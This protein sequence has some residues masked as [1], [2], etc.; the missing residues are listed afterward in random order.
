M[1]F[2]GGLLKSRNPL[3]VYA[4]I[5]VQWP[6]RRW[7]AAT[8]MFVHIS[9]RIPP[10]AKYY[11]ERGT[12]WPQKL[13]SGVECGGAQHPKLPPRSNTTPTAHV[14]IVTP[15]CIRRIARLLDAL[16]GPHAA[17]DAVVD[18]AL[19]C[20][21][22]GEG[23]AKGITPVAGDAGGSWGCSYLWGLNTHKSPRPT[24]ENTNTKTRK[25]ENRHRMARLL[26]PHAQAGERGSKLPC[27]HGFDK[28]R[29]Y[30]MRAETRGG[31]ARR[32]PTHPPR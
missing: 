6:A 24:H 27:L 16:K 2:A 26:R 31:P 12:F 1:Q 20:R 25:R 15:A 14:F 29:R 11:Y 5:D 17:T 21:G 18:A 8:D 28:T 4:T 3:A 9:I 7:D 32:P 10:R 19:A 23:A 30:A 22:S 13:P